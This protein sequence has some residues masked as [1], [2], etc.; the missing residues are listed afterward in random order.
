MAKALAFKRTTREVVTVDTVNNTVAALGTPLAA[1]DLTSAFPG[2][3]NNLVAIYRGQTFLLYRHTANE[4]RLAQLTGGAWVDV[5]GFTA[6]T[7]GSGDLTPICLQVERERI[8]AIAQRSNSAGIDGTLARRS[9][10]GVTWD[11]VVTFTAP[12]PFQ[13][14]TSQG[15]NS[16]VWRNAVFV[17]TAIG[18]IYYIPST[19][20][21]AAAYDQGSDL[22]LTSQYTP[23]GS[24]AFWNGNLYFA[25]GGS[26]PTLYRLDPTWDPTAPPA[27]PAWSRILVTGLNAIGTMTVG[28]DSGTIHMFVDKTD[29][30]VLLYSGSLSTKM[31]RATA[32]TFP[33]FT[34][35]TT[36]FLPA[37]IQVAINYG[38]SGFVDD[39]RRAN[40]LQSFLVRDPTGNRTLLLSWDGVSAMVVRTTFTSLQLMPPDERFGELRTYTAQQPAAFVT[41]TSQPFPGRVSII[42]TLIDTASRPLDVF[43]EYST[44]GDQ[45][46]PMTQGDGDDGNEQLASSPGGTAHTFFWDAFADLDDD[47]P[48]VFQR[49]VAR[50]AGV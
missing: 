48:F 20:T 18:I 50:I 13:P 11:P 5:V 30:L 27:A 26:V 40:E 32:A 16:V 23:V 17:A 33:A 41:S 4:I 9:A 49:I 21:F 2:R 46:L 45:W 7:T 35:V 12:G 6:I 31:A 3:S 14:T 25:V 10:D 1:S 22:G 43:G 47:L 15:G 8:V 28:A 36:T 29:A 19:N 37:E 39:R 24:F 42:Y 44:D 38:F 34:D